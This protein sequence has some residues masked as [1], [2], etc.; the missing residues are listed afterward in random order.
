ML[1]MRS[2]ASSLLPGMQ[3]YASSL[4]LGCS[5][6]LGMQSSGS[7]LLPGVKSAARDA[8]CCLGCSLLLLMQPGAKRCYSS[9]YSIDS[10][11]LRK[12]STVS[13]AGAPWW[14]PV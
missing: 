4:L 9:V 8:V 5:L 3:S 12:I 7:I 11:S 2:S 1:G 13:P 14:L 10:F 6:L